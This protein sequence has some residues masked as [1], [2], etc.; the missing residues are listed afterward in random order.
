MADAKNTPSYFLGPTYI[1]Q[2]SSS[3]LVAKLTALFV[4]SRSWSCYMTRSNIK[5]EKREMK[6]TSVRYPRSEF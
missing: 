4:P 2:Y 5:S 1:R 6:P 3:I